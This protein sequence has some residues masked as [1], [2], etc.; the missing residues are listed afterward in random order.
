[1]RGDHLTLVRN[2]DYRKPGL[3]Y[4]DRI[5]FKNIRDTGTRS[6]SFEKG[7]ID[8]LDFWTGSPEDYKRLSSLPNVTTSPQH[9]EPIV[10]FVAFN[11]KDNKILANLKVRQAI[12]HA[13]DRQFICDK[14]RYGLNPPLD[15]PIPQLLRDFYN[16]N[17][18]KYEYNPAKANKLLDEAGYPRAADGIRFRINLT[19]NSGH[20]TEKPGQIIKPMLREVGIDVDL[21]AMERAVLY[22]K[23]FAKYDYDMFIT[24]GSTSGDPDIG[25]AR[26]YRTKDIRPVVYVNVARYSNP[27]VDRLFDEAASTM[28]LKKRA[29]AYY[30][31]QEILTEELPYIWIYEK[32]EDIN[33]VHSTFKNCFQRAYYGPL[34][35][36]VWWTGGK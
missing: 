35:T 10:A 6:L 5:I 20:H 25:I 27:E 21:V 14:A 34:F 13:I 23:V 19:Y 24:A 7:E 9:G 32:A 17:V 33:L 30:R 36:E 28:D 3:P 29:R 8:L 11:Q 2:D 12:Y 22:D 26:F 4:L 1:V 15:S 18:K 31:I 16:P